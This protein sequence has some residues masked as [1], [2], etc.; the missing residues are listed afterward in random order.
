MRNHVFAML[1]ALGETVGPG[2]RRPAHA[3]TL[4]PDPLPPAPPEL[5]PDAPARPLTAPDEPGTDDDDPN[6]PD[7]RIDLMALWTPPQGAIGGDT[8]GA[9]TGTMPAQYAALGYKFALRYV[10]IPHGVIVPKPLTASEAA[11]LRG[12]GVAIGLVQAIQQP[13]EISAANGTRDG[14]S[15]TDQ[16]QALGYPAGA[17]LWYDL[18]GVFPIAIVLIDYLNN[19]CREA[20]AAGYIPGLYNGP[21]YPL[22]A[23]QIQALIF[24]RYWGPDAKVPTPARGYC[25]LQVH[26]SNVPMAG[27]AVDPDLVLKD[28]R[29]DLPVFWAAS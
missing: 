25:L 7:T 29:G 10:T 9:F 11:A 2:E 21:Q 28:N 6:D 12:L 15:A 23:A 18:E 20:Q 16:A 13:S 14:K 5:D 27:T 8:S 24:P 26:P 3:P 1:F 22:T 17:V 4:P 19:W